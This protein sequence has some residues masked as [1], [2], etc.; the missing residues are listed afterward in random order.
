V[1]GAGVDK[2]TEVGQPPDL[3]DLVLAEAVTL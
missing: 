1:V 3:R 2:D